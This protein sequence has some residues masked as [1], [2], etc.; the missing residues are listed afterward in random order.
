MEGEAPFQLGHLRS[1]DG[2][3]RI[4]PNR[5]SEGCFDLRGDEREPYRRVSHPGE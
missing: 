1:R 5:A 2:A 3:H 4:T